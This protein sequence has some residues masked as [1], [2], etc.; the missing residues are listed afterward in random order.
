MDGWRG[1]VQGW[2]RGLG[3]SLT[4]SQSAGF[5]NAGVGC[6]LDIRLGGGIGEGR[7]E[8]CSWAHMCTRRN[9]SLE[10]RYVG[11]FSFSLKSF[12]F[13]LTSFVHFVRP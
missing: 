8:G 12:L 2:G 7:G 4:I 1:W 11:K 3:H 6:K 9:A 13:I 5:P 10:S